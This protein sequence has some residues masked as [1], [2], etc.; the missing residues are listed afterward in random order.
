MGWDGSTDLHTL[1]VSLWTGG[2]LGTVG[3]NNDTTPII[4]DIGW[5]TL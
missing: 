3:V 1:C 2:S 5:A 4:H